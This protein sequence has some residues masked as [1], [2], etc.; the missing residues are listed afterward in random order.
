MSEERSIV[1]RA[2]W[3]LLVG[4]WATG[5]AL[6]LA[7]TLNVTIIFLPVG[8][9]IINKV[10]WLLSLKQPSQ[11]EQLDI[12]DTSGQSPSLLI[13]GVYFVLAGWWVSGLW[14]AAAYIV[15]LT[16]VGIPLAV[17]MYNKLPYITSLK[18]L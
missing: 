4:W 13:R 11:D 2:I 7:W 12:D 10:P 6:T 8:I 1:V 17:V 14:M 3:F 18:K 5:I 16:V 15:S 9:K